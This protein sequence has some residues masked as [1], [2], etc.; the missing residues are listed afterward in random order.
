MKSALSTQNRQT[1]FLR[2]KLRL[3]RFAGPPG[4][5]PGPPPGPEE[6]EPPPPPPYDCCCVFSSAIRFLP[7]QNSEMIYRL[8]SWRNGLFCSRHGWSW[9][10]SLA[11]TARGAAFAVAL[12]LLLAFQFFVETHGEI[13]DDRIGHFQ[14]ALKLF[15]HF[16][17][18]RTNDHVNE[19]TF[20]QFLHAIGHALTAPFIY[21]VD[22]AA[23]FCGC[24]FKS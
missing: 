21:G 2:T 3:P 19:V 5:P 8:R 12:Q 14:P 4:R 24:V 1:F 7:D 23:F 13:F 18:A 16:A 9:R 22:L 17:M 6:R 11:R 10:N 15:Y 20:A